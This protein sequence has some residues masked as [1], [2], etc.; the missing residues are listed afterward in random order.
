MPDIG[1]TVRES[2]LREVERARELSKDA[3]R[4]GAYLYPVKVRGETCDP[5]CNLR[6]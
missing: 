6:C 1:E 5:R 3:V 2:L 4:S